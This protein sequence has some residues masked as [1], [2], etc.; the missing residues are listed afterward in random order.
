MFSA[1]RRVHRSVYLLLAGDWLMNLISIGYLLIFNILLRKQGYGDAFIGSIT[2]LRYLGV[3]VA[4]LPLGFFIKARRLKP[5][6]LVA[7]AAVP[8]L[9]LLLLAAVQAEARLLMH[10]LMFAWGSAFVISR[11]CAMPYILR[12]VGAAEQSE[13]ISLNYSTR[14]LALLTGG[15][16]ITLLSMEAVADVAP[17]IATPFKELR[18]LQVL[19]V[20]GFAALGFF[21]AIRE[22]AP[23]PASRPR[24]LRRRLADYDWPKVL[25]ALFPTALL[26]IG[27]G[28]TIPFMNLFFYNVFGLDSNEFAQLGMATAV[29]VLAGVLVVPAVRKRYGYGV[30][31]T[32]SQSLSVV[33][34]IAL[35]GTQLL[36]EAGVGLALVLA[37]GF[38][39]LRQ[40][41]MNVA[42]PMSNELTMNYAGERNHEIV[43]ALISSIWSGGWFFS[44]QLFRLMRAHE[45]PYYQ[46]LLLTAVL[47]ASGVIAYAGLIRSHRRQQARPC[48]P[49]AH[50]APRRSDRRQ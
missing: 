32:G 21:A 15:L 49:N 41:L 42:A 18:I 1:Y 26:A 36:A 47:Y 19:S 10:L 24:G 46:I 16:L 40:P 14:S 23:S 22:E 20:L 33:F 6:L 44:G 9:S 37:I 11:V 35:A 13:A 3:L 48:I 2:S 25:R 8:S 29:L 7:G 38:Y 45:L 28:L 50:R 43:S 17:I 5:L 34:L 4:A 39:L 30:A 31:I 27:A 12:H